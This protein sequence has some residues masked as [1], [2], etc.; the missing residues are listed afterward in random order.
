MTRYVSCSCN[1]VPYC[2]D[3]GANGLVCFGTCNAVAIYR[4][5]ARIGRIL[6][7]LHRHR[8]RVTTVRWI[9]P[10]EGA[11][12]SELLSGSVDGT[13]IV[14]SENR[15][16]NVYR[17]TAVLDARDI[18]TFADSLRLSDGSASRD[19]S[20]TFPR[21]LIC[22]GTTS[23]ELKLWSREDNA[24]VR[25][26]QTITFGRK[27][28]IHCRLARLPNTE[29]PLLAVALEDASV[30][31]YAA[32]S[33]TESNFVRIQS[34]LGH[35]D[36]V[37]CIDFSYDNDGSA[38]LA[39]GSQDTT[40]RL[41]RISGI[42]AA[43]SSDELLQ[44]RDIFKANDREYNVTLESVLCGHEGWI[45]GAHWQS[46]KE[47]NSDRRSLRLLSCSLDKSMIVW[48]TDDVTGVWT[49]KVRVGEVG[50]NSLGFY[51]CKFG[52]DGL[53]ILAYSFQGSFHIWKYS[54]DIAN[55]APLY[56]PSGHFSEVVDLC[57][58]PKG[59][60]VEISFA[61]NSIL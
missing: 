30:L 35:K 21:L 5:C 43:S 33:D 49:E 17:D 59:R 2:A 46:V 12:E 22:A 9:G 47:E 4:P 16:S 14:W 40:I 28:P 39:T 25:V 55:W 41:W 26:I 31:L 20:T 42:A 53:H 60:S 54:R 11:P 38:L 1:R 51:G 13:V 27:L 29:R 32:D 48:Q 24:D 61:K 56:A 3:W 37:R 6:H 19:A 44:E 8:D 50:G 10:G 7:T 18:V 23:G 15:E 58:E 45:Y 34:L 57:W 52:P 36:W